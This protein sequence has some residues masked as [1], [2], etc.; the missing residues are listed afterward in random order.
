[1]E[2]FSMDE[3]SESGTILEIEERESKKGQIYHRVKIDSERFGTEWF[4]CWNES[5]LE[6]IE[7]G[8]Y[9]SFSFVKS[10]NFKNIESL[11]KAEKSMDKD[12]TITKLSCLRSAAFFLKEDNKAGVE[13]VISAARRFEDE[14]V[15]GE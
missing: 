14:Y 5:L 9:V 15:R 13:D 10:G 6:G 2:A 11:K 3:I 7:E 1:M 12:K 8:S 4:S